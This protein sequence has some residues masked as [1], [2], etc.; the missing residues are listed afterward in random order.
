[1]ALKE[2]CSNL[3]KEAHQVVSLPSEKYVLFIQETGE[4]CMIFIAG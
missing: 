2:L 1:M 4:R 3:N